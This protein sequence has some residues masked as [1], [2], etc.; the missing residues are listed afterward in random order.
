MINREQYRP[1]ADLDLN[2]MLKVINALSPATKRKSSRRSKYN[3]H[4]IVEQ[5]LADGQL[6]DDEAKLLRTLLA[7]IQRRDTR[8]MQEWQQLARIV[9]D[10][11]VE[12]AEEADLTDLLPSSETKPWYISTLSWGRIILSFVLG[13]ITAI[14][15]LALLPSL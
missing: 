6:T 1:V 4:L 8:E 15:V 12:K 7:Y 11:T 9:Q 2:D 5:L 3:D 14:I 13:I 10:K